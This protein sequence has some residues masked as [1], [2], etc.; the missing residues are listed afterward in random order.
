M[1]EKK[2][3]GMILARDFPPDERPEKEALSLIEAGFDVFML[4]ITWQGRPLKENYKGIQINRFPMSRNLFRKLSPTYLAFPFYR[5]IWRPKIEQF[6][7]ENH[8]NILH[9]HD[10]PMTDIAHDMAKKYG[11]KV[12]CDQ[13]EYWSNWIINTAHYN[14][15]PGKL[16]SIM[17]NWK[18]YECENLS[19][20]DLVITVTEPLRK[21]YIEDGCIPAEKLITV[22][23]TPM[24]ATFNPNK[25]NKEV[26]E[27]FKNNFV[28]FYAGAMDILRGLDVVI[29]ALQKI[30]EKVP[31]IK[32][33]L[34]GRF[35]SGYNPLQMAKDAGVGHLVD[36]VGWL[37]VEQLPSYM[38]AASVCVFAPPATR[39][40]INNTIATKIYQYL[41][42]GKPIIT[43]EAKMMHD[44]VVDHHI[45]WA[46]DS[47]NPAGFAKRVIWLAQNYQRLS[48]E[49]AQNSKKLIE[50]DD[51]FWD[52][53]IGRML[54]AY[55]KL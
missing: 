39:D 21:C 11:C 8:I 16:I 4:S 34:A 37:D 2:R 53:T 32:F 23:N 47:D 15:I 42:M 30:E 22:P 24:R 31:N 33:V 54:D 12:V 45:G 51:I 38:A 55:Q 25:I 10:L 49:I 6:V 1:I 17:S 5:R 7:R 44:F 43:S 52:Q 35:S 50:T 26:I 14:T 36:F 28:I 41:A 3:I 9:V 18:K 40:E 29:N 20:A 13:H 46:I 27:A 19:Q 48:G